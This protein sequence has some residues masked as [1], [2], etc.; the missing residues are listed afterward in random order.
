MKPEICLLFKVHEPARLRLYRFFDIGKD[1][2]YYDDFANRSAMR[3]TAAGSYLPM[4]D[5]ILKL[6]KS[7]K[8]KLKVAFAISG[9]AIEQMDRY[10]PELIDSFRELYNTGCVEFVC[11]PY[12]HSMAAVESD[13]EFTHQI[14]KHADALKKYFGAETVS[15]V[16]TDMVYT[17]TIGE[18][19]AAL[20]FKSV[21]TEGAKHILGWRSPN[22]VYSCPFAPKLKLL[23]RNAGLSDDISLRFGSRE[24]SEWPLTA[25]KYYGW[26]LGNT[27]DQVVNICM[28]YKIF[29]DYF[30]RETGIFDFFESLVNLV[31]KDGK[32]S[33]ATPA[34]AARLKAADALDVQDPISCEDEERDMSKWLG[35]ELQKDAFN[36]LYALQEKLSIVN[37]PQ[38]WEDYGH[39]QETDH[40]YNMSTKFFADGGSNHRY[41]N[42]YDTPYEAF[43]NYMNV[44]ADF[45]LRVENEIN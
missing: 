11:E 43:I 15:F 44:L 41:I 33:F 19:I 42:P 2:H 40:F 14:K 25:E 21:I 28:N 23:L 36:K 34:E 16:N 38:L 20:G 3:K 12:Y 31:V 35:N 9:T 17:D 29:G 10:C 26:L 13:A 4:N 22:Y 8:G 1:S 6:I 45:A 27:G 5:L 7:T 24:W 32:F 37:L 18:K 30:G 39:L